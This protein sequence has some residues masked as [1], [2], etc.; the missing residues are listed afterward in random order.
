MVKVGYP[1]LV[2]AGL[3]PHCF[4]GMIDRKHKG[5]VERVLEQNKLFSVDV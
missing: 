3:N 4:I 5:F 1:L 2:K